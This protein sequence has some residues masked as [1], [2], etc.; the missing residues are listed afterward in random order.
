MD[1]NFAQLL[2]L[3]L[4]AQ[5]VE[6]NLAT[7][8]EW[9]DPRIAKYEAD[10]LS[11]LV[12]HDADWSPPA[13]AHSFEWELE[14]AFQVPPVVEPDVADSALISIPGAHAGRP[15]PK[16]SLHTT[17]HS[18]P[19]RVCFQDDA[20]QR[21]VNQWV[22]SFN[23]TV[24]RSL[25]S[26]TGPRR[27]S[28][29]SRCSLPCGIWDGSLST[30]NA[31][32]TTPCGI[33]DG[34]LSLPAADQAAQKATGAH[35]GVATATPRG[36]WDG[37]MS[38]PIAGLTV[39]QAQV[40]DRPP[41]CQV[42]ATPCGMWDGALS[43]PTADHAVPCGI[44]DGSLS[45]PAADQVDLKV[46]GAHTGLATAAPL[47]K[48]DGSVSTPIAGPGVAQAQV[49][50]RPPYGQIPAN[51]CG[52]WDGSLSTP[53][54]DQV[55]VTGPQV[56]ASPSM[57]WGRPYPA[58][59]EAI[60]EPLRPTD[61][62]HLR[63]AHVRFAPDDF[64]Y[65]QLTW[66]PESL[67]SVWRP[68]PDESGARR[69][70]IFESGG[71]PRVRRC[72]WDW[73][74]NEIVVDAVASS[75]QTIRTVQILNIPLEGFP[76]PQVVLTHARAPAGSLAVPFD[77]RR[78][79]G[80]VTT[81]H[82]QAANSLEELP[83]PGPP[84]TPRPAQLDFE[85]RPLQ[86]L[87]DARGQRHETLTHP[88]DRYEWFVPVFGVLQGPADPTGAAGDTTITTTEMQ[89]SPRRNRSPSPAS[90]SSGPPNLL[91]TRGLQEEG[92]MCDIGLRS[93]IRGPVDALTRGTY[94][95]PRSLLH[96]TQP[97]PAKPQI[98]SFH[99]V[100]N[101]I[102]EPSWLRLACTKPRLYMT[103]PGRASDDRP[104]IRDMH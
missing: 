24:R 99:S 21:Q 53:T 37:S 12:V 54:A 3:Q 36:R 52:M 28:G 4:G 10:L 6:A 45:I 18:I 69:Y 55:K 41:Y 14:D 8:L 91:V 82:V 39:A 33:R 80:W 66:P 22:R 104:A 35:T 15:Y 68:E 73:Q 88:L 103:T 81:L 59:T 77:F 72:G 31:D 65:T 16:S 102:V 86:A 100:G 43:T 1:T 98:T 85:R 79:H 23:C 47:G 60:K 90:S 29:L 32:H 71:R 5:M 27:S 49:E 25:F 13:V 101:L 63:A 75:G 95:E 87:L 89:P 34:S 42:P 84:G 11:G 7:D 56:P 26:T 17:S 67:P 2:A 92:A 57:P 51:P 19:L 70:T 93:R 78:T 61:I 48:W 76:C 9:Q 62:A 64:D 30:P 50:G 94:L 38:T 74:L 96:Q 46:T 20:V 44:R 83:P 97:Y 58:G 40:D